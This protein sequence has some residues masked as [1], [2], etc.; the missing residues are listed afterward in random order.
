MSNTA[1][2]PIANTDENIS[3]DDIPEITD[4]SGFKKSPRIAKIAAIAKAAGRYY[5]RAFDY[6]RRMI[7][8]KEI[9]SATHTV[10]RTK[11]VAF[12]KVLKGDAGTRAEEDC[13][14]QTRCA[15]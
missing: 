12:S 3:F 5:T 11:I 10:I 4:F 9:D 14:L 8:I 13:S 15:V 6:D 7:E 1:I 2:K